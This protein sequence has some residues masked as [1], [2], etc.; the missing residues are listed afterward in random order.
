MYVPFF[1]TQVRFAHF[2]T[3]FTVHLGSKITHLESL[4]VSVPYILLNHLWI[5]ETWFVFCLSL[6][7]Q[8][9]HDKGC[10]VLSWVDSLCTVQYSSCGCLLHLP[11]WRTALWDQARQGFQGLEVCLLSSSFFSYSLLSSSTVT[12][13]QWLRGVSSQA[14]EAFLGTKPHKFDLP[15]SKGAL[16]G[17][18]L[19]EHKPNL[20]WCLNI[21]IPLPITTF[22]KLHMLILDNILPL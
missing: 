20:V 6:V 16:S 18:D 12:W 17:S 2:T 5:N 15:I 1:L 11:W 14:K 8:G 13:T 3:L 22:C 9:C 21:C 7:Y 4:A 10:S 19:L